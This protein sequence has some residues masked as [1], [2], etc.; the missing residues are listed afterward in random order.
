[1]DQHGADGI[2]LEFVSGRPVITDLAEI[3]ETLHPVGF[4]A[5][6]LDLGAAPA[7]IRDILARPTLTDEEAA[8]VQ[9]QFLLSRERLLEIIQAA[10][11]TPRWPAV[12][13]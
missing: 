8:S 3:N 10:G 12:G 5:W 6:P 1:V 9:Q 11:R 7:A 13:R 4:R 2:R